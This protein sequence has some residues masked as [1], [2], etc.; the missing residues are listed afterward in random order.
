[1][2]TSD[3]I[4]L[5]Q[6]LTRFQDFLKQDPDNKTLGLD[7]VALALAVG[8]Y[9]LAQHQ[10]DAGLRR[11]PDDVQ[12]R[13]SQASL[14]S[15]RGDF[16]GAEAILERLIAEGNSAPALLYALA[17]AQFSQG[18]SQQAMA[19]LQ[20]LLSSAC[21]EIPDA[22]PLLMR[23][24]QREGQVQEA[25]ALFRAHRDDFSIQPQA[26]GLASLLALDLESIVEADA[27]S[28]Q[29]LS[30]QPRQREAL[31]A[32]GTLALARQ[33]LTSA[34]QYLEQCLALYPDS[35]RCWSA[36]GL[37]HLQAQEMASA[38]EALEKAVHLMP[39]HIGTWHGLGWCHIAQK[40]FSLAVAAFEA[41]LQLDHNFAESHGGL[42]VALISLQQSTRAQEYIAK[43]LRLDTHCVSALLGQALL[44]GEGK[45]LATL[46]KLA[47][48][49]L[50]QRKTLTGA[51]IA[52]IALRS[53][54]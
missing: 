30:L 20:H 25:L 40:N 39:S 31:I 54:Q 38:A 27:W 44:K 53:L 5:T 47:Q 17:Y 41:A 12:W 7:I 13:H 15:A 51:S 26:W 8:Q 6:R 14:A 36:L 29:A 50:G 34:K 11:F 24:L 3:Q 18:K 9:D 52:E 21:M 46:K 22:L 1:M 33:D 37:T 28:E 19:P 10:I 42:A 2:M 35:G 4:I 45:D 43:A 49:L 48:R 16:F 23:C 32:K